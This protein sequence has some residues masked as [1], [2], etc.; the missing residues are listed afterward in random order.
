MVE[1]RI[2]GPSSQPVS[3]RSPL[4]A[5]PLHLS[6]T[7]EA[8][9]EQKPFLLFLLFL[10]FIKVCSNVPVEGPGVGCGEEPVVAQDTPAGNTRLTILPYHQLKFN[11]NFMSRVERFA[12]F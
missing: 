4:S 10:S 8:P 2:H 7:G 6:V 11:V 5:V 1:D 9:K 12:G 3:A